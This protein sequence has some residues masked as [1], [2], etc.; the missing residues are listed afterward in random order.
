[1]STIG[2]LLR[3]GIVGIALLALAGRAG[4]A[5]HGLVCASYDGAIY[6]LDG[7]GQIV[8]EY[9]T[10]GPQCADMQVLGN[11]NILFACTT[12][13]YE[14]SPKKEIVFR[15]FGGQKPFACQRLADGNTFVGESASGQL[16]VVSPQGDIVRETTVLDHCPKE[17]IPEL[18]LRRARVLENGNYL[19]AHYT[20]KKVCEYTPAG[21]PVWEYPVAGGAF[22]AERLPNGNTLISVADKDK[23]PRLIEVS[24]SKE[25]VWEFA[26]ASI[27]GSAPLCFMTGFDL[28]PNGNILAVQWL[29][30]GH[31]GAF[32]SIFE[33]TRDK[34][35]VRS[36]RVPGNQ[37][38]LTA[39]R[40]LDPAASHHTLLFPHKPE[41]NL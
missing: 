19:V 17:G 4:A 30:H 22:A 8:W 34:R 41:V 16:M 15:F 31:L 11:G 21:D 25:L 5:P 7:A 14:V 20:G 18:F 37:G 27:K 23:N 2:C 29:G 24:R 28:L 9:K 38:T 3:R 36:L 26:N 40:G 6:R 33:I 1:M 39:V 35:I 32:D 10:P 12:G 13:V